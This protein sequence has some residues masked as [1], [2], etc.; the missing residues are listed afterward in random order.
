[1][2]GFSA[3]IWVSTYSRFDR[4]GENY[5]K[6]IADG[7]LPKP[8]FTLRLIF[9]MELY[10]LAAYAHLRDATK[11]RRNVIGLLNTDNC[12][13]AVD[14]GLIA[15]APAGAPFCGD[16]LM[17]SLVVETLPSYLLVMEEQGMHGDDTFLNDATV[18]VPSLWLRGVCRKNLGIIPCR[19]CRG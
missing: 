14:N 9:G 18:G 11:P 5:N 6:L 12:A 8:T 7:S 2:V 10:G 16:F 13:N 4:N 17:Q 19:T 1:M 15:V 3:D